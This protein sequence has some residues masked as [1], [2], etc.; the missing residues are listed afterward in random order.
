MDRTEFAAVTPGAMLKEE[1]LAEY[2]LSHRGL[3]V[4]GH[5]SES[6]VR[7]GDGYAIRSLTRSEGALKVFFDFARA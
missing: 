2:E 4:I 7:N 5:V 1:F 6:Y 3:G